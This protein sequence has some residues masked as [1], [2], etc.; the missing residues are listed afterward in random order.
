[1]GFTM[2]KKSARVRMRLTAV[3]AMIIMRRWVRQSI[4]DLTDRLAS[5]GFTGMGC[6]YRKSTDRNYGA[7]TK[8][9]EKS[10]AVLW[11]SSTS[12]TSAWSGFGIAQTSASRN[13][14]PTSTGSSDAE[15]TP[16]IIWDEKTE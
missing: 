16:C 7:G 14:T 13:L 9:T 11:D 5:K 12:V 2:G 6:T 15:P 8:Q 10:S 1:M 3:S 4:S